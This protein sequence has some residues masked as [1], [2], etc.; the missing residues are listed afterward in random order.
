MKTEKGKFIINDN[1]I[2][3][4]IIKRINESINKTK[5]SKLNPIKKEINHTNK[6]LNLTL[7]NNSKLDLK[8]N[9]NKKVIN[10]KS[11]D[12]HNNCNN[13]FLENNLYPFNIK[14]AKNS[15]K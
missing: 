7:N 14:K 2:K 6:K 3:K 10:S 9:E 11:N 13:I 8:N 12:I 1:N 4:M 5:I 15:I